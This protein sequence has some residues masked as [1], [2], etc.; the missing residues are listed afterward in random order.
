MD[1]R[2]QQV[3]GEI[4]DLEL[5]SYHALTSLLTLFGLDILASCS[6]LFP[7]TSRQNQESC[8]HHVVPSSPAG[9]WVARQVEDLVYTGALSS[10]A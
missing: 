4:V 9:R 10:Q 5:H 2:R 7:T 8:R 1:V 6:S 3:T